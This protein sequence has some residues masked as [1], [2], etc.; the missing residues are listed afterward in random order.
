M[1]GVKGEKLSPASRLPDFPHAGYRSCEKPVPAP[2][3]KADVHDFG[4]KG[5]GI[6]DDTKAFENAIASVNDGSIL[7]PVGRYVN[8]RVRDIVLHNSDNG[9]FFEYLITNL[10]I[11]AGSRPRNSGGA[12]PKT[13]ARETFR[14]LKSSGCIATIV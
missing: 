3:V 12:M 6:M 8:S 9:V 14:N 7:V 5:D 1:W 4:G 11:G 2:E 13:G 10:N